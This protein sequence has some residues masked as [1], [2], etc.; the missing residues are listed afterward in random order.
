M[1]GKIK[2]FYELRIK[3][4]VSSKLS[5]DIYLGW[6]IAKTK[7][8]ISSANLKLEF[9]LSKLPFY[10]VLNKESFLI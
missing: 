4:L 1:G 2:L 9:T 10:I 6:G 7:D 3:V 5:S 8:P